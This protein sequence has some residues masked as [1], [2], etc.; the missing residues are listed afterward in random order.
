MKVWTK[1]D[2]PDERGA[3][4]AAPTP[5]ARV[6]RLAAA[7]ALSGFL[8]MTLACAAAAPALQPF[9]R[10]ASKPDGK[11]SWSVVEIAKPAQQASAAT[12]RPSAE[13]AIE[14]PVPAQTDPTAPAP[15]ESGDRPLITLEIVAE[16]RP[17]A[18]ADE[19]V[20][21]PASDGKY[22]LV[23]IS[24]QH[25]YAYENGELVYSFVAS[26]GMRN[27]TRVGSF[28]VLDKIPNA[29]GENWDIWMPNW[30]GIY[31]SGSLENG[32]H[33]LPVLPSGARLWAGYLGTPISY[34]C[35]VLGVEESQQLYDWAE[36][37]TTV[38]IRR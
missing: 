21:E 17:A 25:L 5:N 18:A 12:D 11:S 32:I 33:A 28:R 14:T 8:W 31:W 37:G 29:Y 24:E 6:L 15:T 38:E 9:G 10:P 13:P 23:S 30:M 4:A 16:D 27:S 36:V 34:G 22:I 2:R 19:V 20:I 35:V 3:L 26:T 1:R 7:A